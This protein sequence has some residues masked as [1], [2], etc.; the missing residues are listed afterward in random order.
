VFVISRPQKIT[1]SQAMSL[2]IVRRITCPTG[3]IAACHAFCSSS[4]FLTRSYPSPFGRL[5]WMI[6]ALESFFHLK[7]H[8]IK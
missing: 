4:L 6:D 3:A 2:P 8:K 5:A 1:P 7:E